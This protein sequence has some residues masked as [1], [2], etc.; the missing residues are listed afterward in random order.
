MKNKYS[1][2]MLLALV[3]SG[4]GS[5]TTSSTNNSNSSINNQ[6]SSSEISS[7]K[8]SSSSTSSSS[9]SSS[10][11][12]SST[13][14][15]KTGWIE[16]NDEAHAINNPKKWF[17]NFD[18][19]SI[20]VTNAM[21]FDDDKVLYF[22]FNGEGS[23][24]SVNLYYHDTY[25]LVGES[26][27]TKFSYT[28]NVAGKITVNGVEKEVRIGTQEISVDSELKEG[29]AV[30]DIQFGTSSTGLISNNVAI[31]IG[32]IY[33]TKVTNVKA[34]LE[35]AIELN[36]YTI[37]LKED[38]DSFNGNGYYG[39]AKF[40][41]NACV[42]T[43][44]NSYDSTSG[45]KGYAENETGIFGFKLDAEGNV[46]ANTYYEIDSND[47][48][49]KGLYSTNE[50]IHLKEYEGDKN[51]DVCE[52]IPSLHKLDLAQFDFD[53]LIGES[54]T[55]KNASSLRYLA[56]M[57]DD[58]FCTFYYSGISAA[59]VTLNADDNLEISFN[60]TYK[61]SKATFV[62]SNIGTT[63]N[64]KIEEFIGSENFAPKED[65]EEAP[66]DPNV[67]SIVNKIALGNYTIL[68]E[69][70]T[71]FYMNSKYSYLEKKNSETNEIE[72]S[73]YLVCGPSIF[74][75]EIKDGSIIVDSSLDYAG[76]FLGQI[77][78]NGLDGLNSGNVQF[79]LMNKANKYTFNEEKSWY[80]YKDTSDASYVSFASKWFDLSPV[81]FN[82][83]SIKEANNEITIGMEMKFDDN[84]TVYKSIQVTNIGNTSVTML[85]E[86]L[87]SLEEVTE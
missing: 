51:G 23:F 18:E 77:A 1:L 30:I 43:Y 25:V 87:A 80:E 67:E 62:I 63:S 44:G 12:S 70:G 38:T 54:I 48:T 73:G 61:S 19:A 28:S 37:T 21:Y 11:S 2:L 10:T 71:K 34:R 27:T 26:Y 39:E 76:L 22:D 47:N 74:R 41:E 60:N 81:G 9:I 3:V 40:F 64:D 16:E 6:T 59:K 35:H 66:I 58:Y 15:D 33:L 4:C 13:G 17:Y 53:I 78:V 36:N 85:D 57:I 69:D 84:E 65:V 5:T 31:E 8:V 75:Y 46:N 56:Y 32:D 50:K 7:S 14:I 82:Y 86:Y 55:V 52:G 20:S 72:V 24:D 79:F 49:L 68:K 42:Y 45:N 83:V 29:N